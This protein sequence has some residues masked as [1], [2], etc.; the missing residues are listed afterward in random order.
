MAHWAMIEILCV[1]QGICHDTMFAKWW[2]LQPNCRGEI[3]KAI[4]ARFIMNNDLSRI[5][6]ETQHLSYCIWYPSVPH[7][8]TCLE[9]I[10]CVPSMKPAIAWVCILVD[11]PEVWTRSTRTRT[12]T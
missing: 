3:E 9:L 12:P 5:K 10:R 11:Y 4:N 6:P 2:S 8:S 7:S 1:I